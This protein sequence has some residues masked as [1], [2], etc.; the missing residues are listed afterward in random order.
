MGPVSKSLG[1][2][3]QEFDVTLTVKETGKGIGSEH[4]QNDLFTPFMQEDPLASGSG[5]GLSIVRQAVNF[6]GGSIEINS[7][8]GVD[9]SSSDSVFNS[10]QT[11]TQGKT[12]GLVG[13]GLSLRS[14]RDTA[15]YSS[16]ERLCRDW[17]NL[18][19]ISVS[20]LKDEPVPFDFYLAVQTELDS[21]DV[22]GRNIFAL[23]NHL[24][25]GNGSS[26]P[27][28]V[29]C[30]SPAEAHSMFVA[31]KNRDETPVFEF[32]SQPCGP[33]KLAR[34][35]SLCMKRQLN[36]Q[37]GRPSPEEPTRWVEM[38]ESSHL[39]LN[40]EVSDP[41]PERMKIS[42][43]P[44]TDAV[45]SPEYRSP[46]SLSSE[47]SRE[48]G[49]QIIAR[50]TSALEEGQGNS[51]LPSSFVLLVDDNDLNLRLLFATYKVHPSKFRLVIL[52]ISMPVMDGFE[53]ARQ[54]RRLE[55]EY[56]AGLGESAR[57]ALPPTIVAALTGLDSHDTQKEAFGFPY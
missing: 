12:I 46:R 53:A 48:V 40:L 15:L 28:V 31:A 49:S 55:K 47:N 8:R 30:Q 51:K 7:T 19:V 35:L 45:R 3:N 54:I 25:G 41:P 22:E 52:D 26:P 18:K 2:Q 38:P 23:N 16:L 44:A 34:A 57:Q 11:F 5:L 17:F 43:R 50:P 24:D 20:L 21:E 4:S 42:K 6:L 14:H 10:L 36:Q 39:P 27:V 29:I 33:R 56:R 37:S 13:F 32:L 9:T 1:E